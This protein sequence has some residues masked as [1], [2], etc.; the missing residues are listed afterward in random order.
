MSP[1]DAA[2]ATRD[3][4]GRSAAPAARPPRAR[5]F[6]ARRSALA[7][8]TAARASAPAPRKEAGIFGQQAQARGH[9]GPQPPASVAACP[10]A[11]PDKRE[12]PRVAA[13]DGM[14]GVAA[15]I[16]TSIIKVRLNSSAASA[17][18]RFI[19]QRSPRRLPRQTSWRAPTEITPPNRT[20]KALSP[21]SKRAGAD[22]QGDGGRMIVIAR[23]QMPG[24]QPVIGFVGGER[25][26]RRHHARAGQI[27]AAM[28]R[29]ALR[30]AITARARR[31]RWTWRNS[32][33]RP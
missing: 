21:N 1:S 28:T 24:P 18:R 26:Q 30:A 10:A 6:S 11:S 32:T 19:L 20:P 22:H 2:T 4:A 23:R 12:T 5:A 13:M 15:S 7:A 33:R 8:G 27:S 9:A 29:P 17:A 25:Q 16:S 14:S 3:W 31:T